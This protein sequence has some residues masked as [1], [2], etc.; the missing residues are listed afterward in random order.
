V[1]IWNHSA[2]TFDPARNWRAK[3]GQSAKRIHCCRHGE[4]KVLLGQ[5]PWVA[6]DFAPFMQRHLAFM[7]ELFSGCRPLFVEYHAKHEARENRSMTYRASAFVFVREVDVIPVMVALHKRVF[8]DRNCWH[9]AASRSA[10]ETLFNYGAMV[11]EE[12]NARVQCMPQ[13]PVTVTRAHEKRAFDDEYHP[14]CQRSAECECHAAALPFEQQRL[15]PTC[16]EIR[17]CG[18]ARIAELH[19]QPSLMATYLEYRASIV[20]GYMTATAISPRELLRSQECAEALWPEWVQKRIPD[21]VCG[22]RDRPE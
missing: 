22:R 10:T 1:T 16:A 18:H 6:A 19:Q 20:A 3:P 8:V 11:G 7:V 4:A 15:A 17:A 13:Q 12:K 2:A 21:V 5:V 9:F 14:L